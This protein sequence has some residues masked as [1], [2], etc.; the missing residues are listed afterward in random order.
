MTSVPLQV[1]IS[2]S[3]IDTWVAKQIA[4]I[5]HQCGASTFLDEADI[6]HGDDFEE[7]ILEAAHTSDELLVL[8]TPWAIERPY[9]WLEIGVFWSQRKRIVGILYGLTAKE[10]SVQERIP[11]LL[12]RTDLLDINHIE[13]YFEQLKR[14][15]ESVRRGNG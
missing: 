14:R 8:L 1:F 4:S 12:K 6:E 11:V 2:H 3:S 15:A 7:R 10:F 13:S 9:I 5:V